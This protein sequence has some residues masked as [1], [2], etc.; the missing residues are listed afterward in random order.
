[1]KLASILALVC[2]LYGCAGVGIVA[3]DDPRK[4]LVD[5][6]VLFGQ[7][8]RPVPAEKLINEAM[9]IYQR[10][11]DPHGL[12]NANREY[13]DFLTSPAVG[14]W[15]SQYRQHGFA[16]RSVTFDNRLSKAN[17]FYRRSLDYYSQATTQL[18]D[19][20]H[21]DALTNV[22]YNMARVHLHFGE[23]DE[24]CSDFDLTYWAYT[25][26][27]QRNPSAKPNIPA[28]FSS[29]PEALTYE[30]ERAGCHA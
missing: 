27:M 29:L 14:N 16:D 2:L 4:K 8:N 6:A 5:A 10:N 1:M 21:Y 28:R 30:R 13:G 11:D 23:K 9:S 3:T 17:E 22:Y 24:A 25:E 12:G 20:G 19:A 18:K 26:N 7:E 15:E